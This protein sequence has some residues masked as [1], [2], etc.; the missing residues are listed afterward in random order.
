MAPSSHEVRH[1]RSLQDTLSRRAVPV[2]R[3]SSG[4]DRSRRRYVTA[5]GNCGHTAVVSHG[6]GN[7]RIARRL[8]ISYFATI[9]ATIAKMYSTCIHVLPT[10]NA[11]QTTRSSPG[12]RPCRK[13]RMLQRLGGLDPLVRVQRQALLQQVDKVV[14]VPH[15]RVIH[16]RR[17]SHQ[18]RAE[19]PRRLDHRQGSHRRLEQGR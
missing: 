11:P 12:R 16:P 9:F 17:G 15:L 3:D 10:A 8:L 2:V 7:K 5:T 14:E 19:V 1:P 13:K 18:A 4:T 6:K